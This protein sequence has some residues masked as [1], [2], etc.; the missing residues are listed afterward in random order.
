MPWGTK[1]EAPRWPTCWPHGGAHLCP[2]ESNCY[3]LWLHRLFLTQNRLY[4]PPSGDFA[5]GQ[6]RN[7]KYMKQMCKL[8]GYEGRQCSDGSLIANKLWLLKQFESLTDS[9]WSNIL[10]ITLLLCDK[11]RHVL[12][13]ASSY[14]LLRCWTESLIQCEWCEGSDLYDNLWDLMMDLT[15][16]CFRNMNWILSV[17]I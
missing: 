7:T 11:L 5:M 10:N 14:I 4:I 17:M 2:R 8:Q 6:Q 12:L 13:L 1:E 15:E 3:K 16:L 9:C